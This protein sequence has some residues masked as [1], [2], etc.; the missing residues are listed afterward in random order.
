MYD[1]FGNF[2]R[3]FEYLA[4]SECLDIFNY[5]KYNLI[6]YDMSGCYK[7]GENRCDQSYHS[8]ISKQDGSI[9]RN[10]SIHFDAIKAS[11]VKKGDAVAITSV[12]LIIPY[13]DNWILVETSSDTVYKYIYNEDKLIPLI[14]RKTSVDPKVLFTVWTLDGRYC[15][16]QTIKKVFDITKGDGFQI[17]DIMYGKQGNLVCEISVFNSDFS[18]KQR[19]NRTSI[20]INSEIATFQNLLAN[21][22]FEA[23]ENGELK[24]KLK[25][26]A[27]EL[28]D[29]SNPV[30]MLM[31]YKK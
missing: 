20:S 11:I 18:K 22:L 2:K 4:G 5:D 30:V 15:F 9:T 12:R 27:A 25:E 29:E 1:L 6:R 31:K 21:Q 23:Y 10:I 17:T 13:N 26:I 28:D 16:M 7:E 3:S 8:I 24:G 19:E 14:V